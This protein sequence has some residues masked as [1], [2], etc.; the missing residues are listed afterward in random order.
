MG[1]SINGKTH[2]ISDHMSTIS[3]SCSIDEQ[4][5]PY[6]MIHSTD[7][8]DRRRASVI[9]MVHG[10]EPWRILRQIVEAGTAELE[11]MKIKWERIEKA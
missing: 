9:T 3:F 8:R 4:G 6:L 1:I 11:A 10:D 2:K 5:A 7:D